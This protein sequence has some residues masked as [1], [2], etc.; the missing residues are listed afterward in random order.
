MS[1]IGQT[2]YADGLTKIV[3]MP[4]TPRSPP[5]FWA[6]AAGKIRQCVDASSARKWLDRMDSRRRARRAQRKARAI[7]RRHA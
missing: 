4:R 2:I 1:K 5:R 6:F 7:T 3:R